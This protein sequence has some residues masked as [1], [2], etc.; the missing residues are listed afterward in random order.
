MTTQE[1]FEAAQLRVKAVTSL[2]N[3]TLLELYGLY[4]QSTVGDVDGKRPGMMDIRGRAKYDAWASRKSMT[5]E[6]AMKAYVALVDRL[7]SR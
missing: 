3:D 4:K 2:S 5:R 6:A 7:T 1:E